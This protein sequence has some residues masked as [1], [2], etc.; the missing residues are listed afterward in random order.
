MSTWSNLTHSQPLTAANIQRAIDDMQRFSGPISIRP[1]TLIVPPGLIEEATHAGHLA[2]ER[3]VRKL[4]QPVKRGRYEQR[5]R[6]QAQG[7]WTQ[8][9]QRRQR[10]ERQLVEAID[11]LAMFERE[12]GQE[13]SRNF[14]DVPGVQ[15]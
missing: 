5:Q 4:A 3:L 11:F 12:V 13:N 7:V 10:L 15:S 8:R 2:I 1:D 14:F 6:R 9:L